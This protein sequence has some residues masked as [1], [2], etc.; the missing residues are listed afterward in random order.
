MQEMTTT[1]CLLA[2][3]CKADTLE[4]REGRGGFTGKG[5]GGG[6]NGIQKEKSTY[7]S[8]LYSHIFILQ[9][10]HIIYIYTYT[11]IYR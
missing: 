9:R 11:Y 2:A 7:R 1:C 4:H 5:I 10:L 3:T 8:V 6:G